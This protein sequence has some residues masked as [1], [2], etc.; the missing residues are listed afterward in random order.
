M[1][2]CFG[3]V[4]VSTAKQG[5]GVSL[6]EQR[7]AIRRYAVRHKIEMTEWFEEKETAASKEGPCSETF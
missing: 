1:N 7:E 5:A 3:Y 4:R 6:A 2:R